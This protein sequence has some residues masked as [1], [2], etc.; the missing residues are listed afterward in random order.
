MLHGCRTP[1]PTGGQGMGGAQME[2]TD[3][4]PLLASKER[5]GSAG[6]EAR[7]VPLASPARPGWRPSLPSGTLEPCREYPGN[8]ASS[9][10]QTSQAGKSAPSAGRLI[11]GSVKSPSGWQDPS[12]LQ[13]QGF[14][15]LAL[16]TCGAGL[17]LSL[18][19][20]LGILCSVRYL[21]SS[22]APTC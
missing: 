2:E 11:S 16:L 6:V 15:A 20:G 13:P 1:A 22:L 4:D 7:G 10:A 8:E 5:A 9:G 3:L 19:G 12:R 21:A 18:G 14:S 17:F